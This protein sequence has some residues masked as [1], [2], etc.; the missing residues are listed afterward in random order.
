M[1]RKSMS[2]KT[3]PTGIRMTK[4]GKYDIQATAG[5]TRKFRGTLLD[6]FMLGKQRIALFKVPVA[7]PRG[8]GRKKTSRKRSR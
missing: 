1:P 5:K 3:P 6:T 8:V 7:R 4:G 2:K